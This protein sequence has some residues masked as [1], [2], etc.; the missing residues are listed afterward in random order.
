MKT[1]NENQFNDKVI[2]IMA[3][4]SKAFSKEIAELESTP[5]SGW[6]GFGFELERDVIQ[7]AAE[8]VYLDY[9]QEFDD[10]KVTEDA[11]QVFEAG[12]EEIIKELYSRISE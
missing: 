2:V 11:M 8:N 6:S 12:A 3:A 4:L 5:G 10:W 9:S 7:A 1:Y